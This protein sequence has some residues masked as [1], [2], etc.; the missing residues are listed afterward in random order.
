VRA[1]QHFFAHSGEL[2]ARS[3]AMKRF[4]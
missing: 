1:S 4:I 2:G 3:P